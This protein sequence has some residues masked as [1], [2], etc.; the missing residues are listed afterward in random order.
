M[1]WYLQLGYLGPEALE[2][3]VNYS[4]GIKIKGLTSIKGIPIYKCDS[5]GLAK[6]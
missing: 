3:L 6:A 4:H 2:C 5:C 1:K